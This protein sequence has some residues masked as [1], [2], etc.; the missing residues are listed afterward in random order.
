LL[1]YKKGELKEM[2]KKDTKKLTGEQCATICNQ[3]LGSVD[4]IVD[5]ANRGKITFGEALVK[6]KKLTKNIEYM[7]EK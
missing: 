6:I 3:I 4:K 2:V 7:G 1:N 5:Q